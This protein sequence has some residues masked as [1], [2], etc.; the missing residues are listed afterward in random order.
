[1]TK[2]SRFNHFQPWHDGYYIAFNARSGAVA[3]M[4]S[5][6]YQSYLRLADKIGKSNGNTP[7]SD[8]ESELLKQLEYGRFTYP[9]NQEEYQAIKFM[10]G[11]SRFDMTEMGLVVAPTLACNMACTY[12]FESNKKGKMSAEII[13]ALIAFVEARADTL[14]HVD[15]C[16]YGGEPLLAVDVIEDI[17]QSMLEM[18][19]VKNFQYTATMISNGYLLTREVVEKLVEL[20]VSMVQVTLDGP[21]RIHETKRPLKNGKPSFAQIIENIKYACTRLMVGIRINVDKGF[22][23][24]D[25]E[26][27][28]EELKAAGLQR[29]V[30]I[31]FGQL[32]PASIACSNITDSCYSNPDFSGVESE[33]FRLLL[34]HGFRIEK[35]P[36]P[37]SAFCMAQRVNAFLID[38]E[39]NLYRCFNYVGDSGKMMGNIRD[40]VDYSHPNFT[41][42]FAFNAFEDEEC[43]GC[44]LLP[45]CLGGCPAQRVDRG[46]QHREM[47]LGWKHNL[48]PMLEIIAASR[49]QQAAARKETQV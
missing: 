6:N 22:T 48:N 35:L 4:T 23:A 45:I 40:S 17:S 32:E 24:A 9:D 20:K 29:K 21:A 28:L 49:Q 10:H 18:A 3:L 2:I 16:W 5:E 31:Y 15:I 25:I 46:L 42:L 44:T 34:K 14:R 37:T 43:S 13:E 27:L 47:C 26:E 12:C 19:K 11:M 30:G 39:G 8:S 7:L 1:M 36:S 41:R 33:Y 38:H